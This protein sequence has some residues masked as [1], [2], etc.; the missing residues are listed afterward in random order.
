MAG[1][2]ND[3]RLREKRRTSCVRWDTPGLWA[4]SGRSPGGLIDA[5]PGNRQNYAAVVPPRTEWDNR[6][7]RAE[8]AGVLF[9]CNFQFDRDATREKKKKER[10]GWSEGRSVKRARYALYHYWVSKS[11]RN[12]YKLDVQSWQVPHMS[13]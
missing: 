13:A 6:A 7:G 8:G 2:S 3:R 5:G 1:S 9:R 10:K 4:S 12:R 11:G